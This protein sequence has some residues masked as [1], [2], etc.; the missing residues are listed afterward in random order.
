MPFLSEIAQKLPEA[1]SRLPELSLNVWY[2]WND[3]ALR[4]FR[5]IDPER[6]D[7]VCHN[8]VR[9]LAETDAGTFQRLTEQ[10]EYMEAYGRVVRR[11]DDYRKQDAWFQKTY[12]HHT[13]YSIAYFSAEFGFHES[14]PIYSGGLG[15]L[16]GDHCKSASDL[17]L[18][19]VGIGLLYKKGYFTQKIDSEGRQLAEPVVYDFDMLPILPALGAGSEPLYV[20]LPFPDRTVRLQVWRVDVG[21]GRVYLLDADIDGNS[22]W[23]RELTAQLYG[24]NQDTRIAQEIL[25]GMGGVKALRALHIPVVAYHINEGHAAFMAFERL[26]EQLQRGVPFHVAVEI[27]RASTVFTTHTPVPAGHDAFPLPMFEHYF[28]PLFTEWGQHRGAFIRLGLDEEKQLFNM[29]HLALNTS[30]LRGGV[31][32]LHGHVSR[33]MFRGFHGNIN[34]RDVPIGHITNGVHMGT[35]LAPELKELYDR[36]LP[37]TWRRNPCSAAVWQSIDLIPAE[38]LWNTHRLLKQ[39]MIEFARANLQEQRRRNGE[40][41][42]HVEEAGSYLSPEALTIGFARRFAT[43]KRANLLF[44]DLGRLE[45]IVNNPERPVQ[46]IFAGKAHPADHPG[47]ELIREIYRVSRMDRF[48]G[49]IVLL[50]NYDMNM[51]R[52]LVQGVDVWLNNP[53]RPYEASGTSGEKAAMNGV[54]NFSV[55]DGWWEEGYDGT[56][57]WSIE[58]NASA[59]PETQERE[60]TE[61]LY[62]VLEQDIVPLYYSGGGDIPEGW[63]ARMKRSIQTLAPMYNTDRMVQEYTQKAYVPTIER[64]LRFI[65]NHNEEAAKVADYKQFIIVNWHRVRIVRVTDSIPEGVPAP[66]ATAGMKS[67]MAALDLGPVWYKDVAVEAVYY[68]D[69]GGVWEPVT[70]RLA[71]VEPIS[72]SAARF[73]G[74]IPAH[75]QHGTHFSVRVYSVSPSFATSFELPLVTST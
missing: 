63:V 59:D 5:D 27:V 2:S 29:T 49:K 1:L 75:L 54:I 35:W 46:F 58:A 24:G 42:E 11:W 55:L 65:A 48:R 62:R 19:L 25:L 21:R 3:D 14:L 32:K 36:F 16:A 8:P 51:A 71:P 74:V 50:E 41:A 64:T 33:S 44:R 43:Y 26:R 45:R 68:E 40:P 38:S 66:A 17:G 18:P 20:E 72:G 73:T 37:G 53:R 22:P 6:F 31:S 34:T 13:A 12:P 30:A 47:Q 70:V 52:H 67:V 61:S 23:D 9:L 60:N 10:P 28:A 15:I 56:N 39:R 57:G 69:K 4:L 7:A